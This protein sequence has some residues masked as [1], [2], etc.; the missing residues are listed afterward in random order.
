[1]NGAGAGSAVTGAWGGGYVTDV[2]YA[3]GY[4]REQSPT[5]LRAA[6]LLGGVA[7]DVPEE[8]AHYLELGCGQGFGAALIAAA[9]PSWRVTAIDFAPAHIAAA[10]GL[11]REAGLDNLAYIEADLA[12]FAGTAA[13]T[14]LPEADIVTM[15]GVWS[16]VAPSVRE[17]VVRLL[18]DKL[19]AGGVAHVSYNALPGWQRLLGLQR[20]VREAG[21]RLA[22]RSDR[23]VLAGFEV[24]RALMA[25]EAGTLRGD[26][27]L[28]RWL[29]MASELSPNYLAHE[30]MNG[31]WQPC[32]HADV[33]GALAAAKLD[34]VGT[35]TLPEAF[36]DFAMTSAQREIYE[37]FSDPM[38]RE[39]VKDICLGRTLRHDVYVRGERR[40]SEQARDD[41]LRSL[42]LALAVPPARVRYEVEVGAGRAELSTAFYGPIVAALA[43][44]PLT[45]AELLRRAQR[46]AGERE[47][48]AELV[49]VLVGTYQAVVL[50]RSGAA[51]SQAAL[52]LNHVIA[53]RYGVREHMSRGGALASTALGAAL[54]QTAAV[55]F[56]CAQTEVVWPPP[57][58]LPPLEAWTEALGPGLDPEDTARLRDALRCAVEEEIPLLRALGCWPAGGREVE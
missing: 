45:V 46:R 50:A 41:A 25:A 37:R 5:Q 34:W 56:A 17:G 33:A 29:G 55:L 43:E 3:H 16:W 36:P 24:A 57:G 39:L 42:T 1:M 22:D 9:N 32:W 28:A 30:Y 4:Y 54:P 51:I 15:H 12:T 14:A 13:C 49:G 19:R 27:L 35:A 31:H 47:N 18:A 26:P 53:R 8:G 2:R 7:W 38:A 20:V 40:L 52:R 6:C 44:G 58:S 21:L 11:A 48:P 10:R 23:Q